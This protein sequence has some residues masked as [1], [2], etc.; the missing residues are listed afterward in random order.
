MSE[1]TAALTPALSIVLPVPVRFAL[2]RRTIR[3]LAAQTI[4]HRLELLLVV[5]AGIGHGVETSELGAFAVA[6]VVDVPAGSTLTECRVAGARAARA[7]IVAFAE[8]HSFPMPRWA[9][10]LERAH[11]SGFDAVA[12]SFHNGNPATTLSWADIT[13]AFGTWVAPVPGGDV[14]RLPWH[15][16]SYKR[17]LLLAFGDR[18]AE[19]LEVE[20]VLQDEL[21]ARGHRLYLD[22]EIYTQH[23]NFSRLRPFVEEYYVSGRLFGGRRAH[24]QR[25]S[26]PRR[27]VY[28]LGSPLIPVKRLPEVVGQ[29]RRMGR[30]ELLP[31]IVPALLLGLAAHSLGE[32]VGYALGAGDAGA[33]KSAREFDRGRFVVPGDLPTL[34]P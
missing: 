6:R 2:V 10:S 31:R 9:E 22:P 23:V 34:A 14:Q 4:A 28:A 20:S 32:M 3:H 18:L 11:A 17:D 13:L 1:P 21:R 8:D 27:A 30:G 24:A 15:N 19:V 29:L 7:R 33:Q 25:W 5:P 16:T 26:L 12:P